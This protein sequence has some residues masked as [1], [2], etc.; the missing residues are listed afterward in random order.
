MGIEFGSFSSIGTLGVTAGVAWVDWGRYSL[1]GYLR[2]QDLTLRL[3]EINAA[4]VSGV[5][6]GLLKSRNRGCG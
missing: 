4:D 5:I 1:L 6:L 3:R 2:T